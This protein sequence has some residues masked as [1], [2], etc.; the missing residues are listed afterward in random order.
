MSKVLM[1][2]VLKKKIQKRKRCYFETCKKKLTLT[3]SVCRCKQ[4]YCSLHRLPESHDC[5]YNFKNESNKAFMKRVGL[6][7]GKKCKLEII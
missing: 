4:R 2:K 5:S 7:G 1:T 6:G 3:N